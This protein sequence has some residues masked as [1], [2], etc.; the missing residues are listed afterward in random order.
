MNAT[1]SPGELLGL[2]SDAVSFGLTFLAVVHVDGGAVWYD[3]GRIQVAPARFASEMQDL[4]RIL[5]G[6]VGWAA[7]ADTCCI[8]RGRA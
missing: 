2:R 7:P 4:P 8:V 6:L 1:W 5:A 3:R